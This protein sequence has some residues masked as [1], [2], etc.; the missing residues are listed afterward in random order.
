VA[1][2]EHVLGLKAEV[3]ANNRIWPNRDLDVATP[4]LPALR[5]YQLSLTKAYRITS[6]R[7]L[8]QHPPYFHDGS[9]KTLEDVVEHYDKVLSLGLSEAQQGDLAEFLKTL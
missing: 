1:L 8:W 3:D 6:L 9:K 7:G 4:K 2:R 5:D